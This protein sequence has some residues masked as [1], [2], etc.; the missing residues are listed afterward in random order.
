VPLKG[1]IDDEMFNYLF[2]NI[3]TQILNAYKPEVLV[4]QCGADSLFNDPIDR[5]N[6]F[7]LTINGYLNCINE[8][9]ETKI[10]AIFLG[11]GGYDFANTSRLWCSITGLLTKQHL[12]QDIPEHDYYLK[13][14]NN[15]EINIQKGNVKNKN[16]IEEVNQIIDT[17]KVNLKNVN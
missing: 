12:N 2:R 4:V 10:P 5:K 6:P 11:G 17:I 16:T 8:I 14:S 7:N 13:Y 3:F 15:Y 9:I 1:G